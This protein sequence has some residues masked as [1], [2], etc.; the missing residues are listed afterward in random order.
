MSDHWSL[1]SGVEYLNGQSTLQSGLVLVNRATN[2]ATS[3]FAEALSNKN[4]AA[5]DMAYGFGN[6]AAQNSFIPTDNQLRSTY[7]YVSVPLQVGY[8]LDTHWGLGLNGTFRRALTSGVQNASAVQ[9]FP[10]EVGVGLRVD[11]R[12]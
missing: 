3:L 8:R 5:L 2:Q 6:L 10:R 7:Q 9:T 11:Y 12:F 1:E 4:T